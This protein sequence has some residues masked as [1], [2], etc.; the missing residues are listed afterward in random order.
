[1][2]A[3]S[4]TYTPELLA[5]LE[6]LMRRPQKVLLCEETVSLRGIRQFY[7]LVAQPQQ[8]GCHSSGLGAASSTVA[9]VESLEPDAVQ[10]GLLVA[11][12]DA[13]LDLLARVSFHQVRLPGPAAKAAGRSSAADACHCHSP[14]S[15]SHT[16]GRP[17]HHPGRRVLQPQASC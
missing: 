6:P 14:P 13:L 4:A 11:K 3:F 9:A 7:S 1:M 16:H 10:Q 12:V 8:R 15:T 17:P 5:D 2:L